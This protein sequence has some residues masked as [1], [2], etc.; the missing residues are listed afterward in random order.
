M[1]AF[2]LCQNGI[3][4]VSGRVHNPFFGQQYIQNT[5]LRE[6]HPENP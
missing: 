2:H 1:C 6:G 3:F 5:L 4:K